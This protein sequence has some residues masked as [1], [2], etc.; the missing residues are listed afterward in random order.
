MRRVK[1][2][3]SHATPGYLVWRLSMRWRVAMDRA[4]APMGL[5]HAQYSLLASLYA[6]SQDGARPSQRELADFTGLDAIY[7]S[8]LARMLESGGFIV[9]T[10][11]AADPR[12]VQLSLTRTGTKVVRKAI[13]V[14]RELQDR[15]TQPLGG[16]RA[17]RTGE[18]VS[19][20]RQLLD[21][22]AGDE[23]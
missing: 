14:V 5:T 2:A 20:L 8:K 13:G 10:T 15:L 16:S 9:R 12:A 4:L 17:K 11:H 7:V 19:M 1:E 22:A 18:L 6:L 23:A 21:H 3:E